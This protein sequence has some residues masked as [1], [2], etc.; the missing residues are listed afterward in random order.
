MN[1]TDGSRALAADS[2]GGRQS[3][4]RPWRCGTGKHVLGRVVRV[5][6]V[7][8]LHLEKA[9]GHVITGHAYVWCSACAAYREWHVGQDGMQE[10]LERMGVTPKGCA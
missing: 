8:R 6:G 1:E 5:N 9:G 7:R 4:H 3:A 2:P 10:M